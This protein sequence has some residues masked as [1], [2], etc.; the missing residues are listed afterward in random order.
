MGGDL[1]IMSVTDLD[2]RAAGTTRHDLAQ[3]YAQR[4]AAAIKNT[5]EERSTRR[6]IQDTAEAFG[7]TVIFI[8]LL[9][10]M[11]KIFPRLY[12]KIESWQGTKIP[13]LRIQQ[14]ELMAAER[15]ARMAVDF[16]RL[17]RVALTLCLLYFYASLVLG[18][19][20]FTRGYARAL[21]GW[22]FAP[23]KMIGTSLLAYLPE[24]FFAAVILTVAYAVIKVIHVIFSEIGKGT[25]RFAKFYPE[26]A[27]PTFNILRLLILAL[28]AVVVFPY[29]PGSSSPAFRG[30]SIFVG[31]LFSLGS[32]SAVA[33]VVSGVILT[34]MRA[35]HPGERVRIDD[36]VGDVIEKN[37]LITRL[38]TIKNEEVT[39]SNASVLGSQIVNYSSMAQTQGL[40]LH[41]SVTI[42]YNAPWRTVHALLIDAALGTEHILRDPAPFVW[43]TALNDFYVQYEINAYTDNANKMFDIYAELNANIQ[44]KF[45]E[46]G[47]EIM[48]PHYTSV[49]DGN[50]VTIPESHLPEDYAAPVFRLGLN[51]PDGVTGINGR[52]PSRTTR[53]RPAVKP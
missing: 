14:F 49:R 12:A 52:S 4:I 36:T 42:G 43:Q 17:A 24:L 48:S 45:N 2:A 53:M 21:L 34:Y 33:N 13:S 46:G 50:R 11:A 31:V 6:R 23:L 27:E 16:V 9:W 19:F 25:I 22:V 26:W 8:A 3:N 38:R 35:F 41:T 10:L 7:C 20:P 47:V 28:T 15:M 5:R 39:I 40:I 29:L 44:D 32:T 18:F 1:I 30:I 37:L 51:Q